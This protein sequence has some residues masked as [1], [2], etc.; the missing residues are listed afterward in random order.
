MRKAL[1]ALSG[2]GGAWRSRSPQREWVGQQRWTST[3][4]VSLDGKDSRSAR[5]LPR[6]KYVDCARKTVLGMY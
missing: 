4:N 3:R 1:M 5:V 6:V 2:M